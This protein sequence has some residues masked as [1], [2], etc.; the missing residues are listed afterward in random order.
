MAAL[1]GDEPFGLKVL[2]HLRVLADRRIITQV[3]HPEAVAKRKEFLEEN[4]NR[5]FG[6]DSHDSKEARIAKYLRGDIEREEPD[7]II[8]LHTCECKVAKSGIIAR[9]DKSLIEVCKRLGMDAVFIGVESINKVSLLGQDRAK[10]IVIEL[11]LGRRS[12]F[13]AESLA[14]HITALLDKQPATKSRKIPVYSQTSLLRLPK[15]F[16]GQL[17]NYVYSEKLGGYPYLVGNNTYT[18]YSGF[19]AKKLEHL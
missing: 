16:S 10:T 6:P 7:L 12:D 13:L 1:H 8:D 11:G 3:G 18:D 15:N 4:L 9:K 2:G 19:M 17:E 14:R 5:A